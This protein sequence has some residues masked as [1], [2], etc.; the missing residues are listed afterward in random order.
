[1]TWWQEALSYVLPVVTAGLV[2]LRAGRRAAT[3]DALDAATD[4][5]LEAALRKRRGGK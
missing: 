5:A 4:E 1:V 2:G 3:A